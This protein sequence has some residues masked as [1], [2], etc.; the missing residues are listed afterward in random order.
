MARLLYIADCGLTLAE[1]P[2]TPRYVTARVEHPWFLPE[3]AKQVAA[4]TNLLHCAFSAP[5]SPVA[6]GKCEPVQ[7]PKNF[8]GGMRYVKYP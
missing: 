6:S 8:K 2:S 5:T 7:H 4:R 1:H 3:L